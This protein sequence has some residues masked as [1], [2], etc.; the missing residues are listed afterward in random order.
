MGAHHRRLLSL[1]LTPVFALRTPPHTDY[2]PRR[3]TPPPRRRALPPPPV[4]GKQL[5]SWLNLYKTLDRVLFIDASCNHHNV[6][7]GTLVGDYQSWFTWGLLAHRAVFVRYNDCGETAKGTCNA[8]DEEGASAGVGDPA[9]GRVDLG[10]FF[11]GPGVRAAARYPLL[12]R[13][14][15]AAPCLPLRDHRWAR[16]SG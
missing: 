8:F 3:P 16:E 14:G 5:G 1:P 4:A 10:K 2:T 11:T 12:W 6:G 9:C 7:L 13:C 15:R